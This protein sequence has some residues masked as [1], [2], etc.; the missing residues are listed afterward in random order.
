M[1]SQ[2]HSENW[3]TEIEDPRSQGKAD[4]KKNL[5]P[6]SECLFLFLS[7]F[8]PDRHRYLKAWLESIAKQ[9]L[10]SVT[11]TAPPDCTN[12]TSWSTCLSVTWTHCRGSHFQ[13]QFETKT[14]KWW[15]QAE[16]KLLKNS[17]L[18]TYRWNCNSQT[19]SFCGKIRPKL[20]VLHILGCHG[21]AYPTINKENLDIIAQKTLNLVQHYTLGKTS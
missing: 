6:L 15:Q 1:Q 13:S 17:F 2:M 19:H 3:S 14:R 4:P 21:N 10:L 11:L 7:P 9:K 16:Q 20:K 18:T 12:F 5:C 8:P